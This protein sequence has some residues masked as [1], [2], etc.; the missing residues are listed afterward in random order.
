M[1]DPSN[2][3]ALLLFSGLLPFLIV[4]VTSFVKFS[5]VLGLLRNALGVQNLPANIILYSM[6]VMLS[7]Y[8][9]LPMVVQSAQVIDRA[10]A[11][12]KPILSEVNNIVKPFA[13]FTKAHAPEK[14]LTFYKETAKKLWGAKLAEELTGKDATPFSQLIVSVPAFLTSE[15]TKAFLIGFMLYLPFVVIDLVVAN[16]LLSLGMSTLSPITISLPLKL[17]LFIGL[18]GWNRLFEA[19][20]LSYAL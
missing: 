5:V 17:L 19:L 18:D 3:I 7:L 1:L 16:V 11:T 10:V 6:A 13:E 15:L 2:L 9:M 8:V 20:V 12:R 14:E 4:G